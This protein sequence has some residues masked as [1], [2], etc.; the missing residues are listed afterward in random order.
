MWDAGS[1]G[2]SRL[3][4]SYSK[5]TGS[6]DL[7]D[8]AVNLSTTDPEAHFARAVVLSGKGEFVE[9]VDELERSTALRPRD[10]YLWME[11]GEAREHL[12]DKQGALAAFSEA[13]RR[14]PYYAYPRW[15]LGNFYLRAG[16]RG[17]AFDELRRAYASDPTFLP[18]V[19]DLAW[20][21]YDGDTRAVR[22]AI[23]PGTSEAR[24]ALESFFIEQGEVTEALKMFLEVSHPPDWERR[25]LLSRLLAAK[26]F[27]E[28]YEVWLKGR[29]PSVGSLPNGKASITDGDFEGKIALDEPGFGWQFRANMPTVRALLDTSDPHRGA[30]SLRLEYRGNSD[31]TVPVV[32]ELVLVEPKARYRLSFAART[33]DM[34]TGGSPLVAVTDASDERVL[35][36]STSLPRGTSGWRDYVLDF[37]TTEKTSA[38]LIQIQRQGCEDIPCPVFGYVWFDTFTLEKS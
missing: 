37:V 31:P 19:T 27:T 24:F 26:R 14:A 20:R 9:A 28:S 13:A 16:Q 8:R 6:I 1:A 34:V 36:Q 5:R 18:T 10:F 7:S 38:V 29:E 11:L 12:G 30:Q 17:D 22:D 2:L 32:S 33:R 21:A 23:R 15:Y 3:F 4:S 35:A 25:E